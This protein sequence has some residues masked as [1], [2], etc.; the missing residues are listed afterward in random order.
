[1]SPRRFR[2]GHP[3]GSKSGLGRA[4]AMAWNAIRWSSGFR[5]HLKSRGKIRTGSSTISSRV[6]CPYVGV[7]REGF[8]YEANPKRAHIS[9][10]A[11][12]ST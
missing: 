11:R 6:L 12:V 7:G 1:M 5:D 2:C 8:A 10:R 3:I 9:G 4:L